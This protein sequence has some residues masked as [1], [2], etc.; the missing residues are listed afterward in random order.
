MYRDLQIS[1]FTNA[2]RKCGINTY[3]KGI[4]TDVTRN[5]TLDTKE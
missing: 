2:N 5:T 3:S 4:Y 1:T